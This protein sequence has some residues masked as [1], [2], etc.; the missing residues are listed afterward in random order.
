[1][2]EIGWA[3]LCDYAFMD[4]GDKRCLIGI[5]QRIFAVRVPAQHTRSALAA[6]IKG[7]PDEVFRPV[8]GFYVPTG[9]ISWISEPQ[10]SASAPQVCI[11]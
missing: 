10:T 1:M 4:Q 3:H 7:R 11:S 6:E 8:F 9:E 2:A 5:F